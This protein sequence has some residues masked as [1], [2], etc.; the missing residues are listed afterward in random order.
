LVC[1]DE[2]I[3]KKE[4]QERVWGQNCLQCAFENKA[5]V[6][7]DKVVEIQQYA[8][9]HDITLRGKKMFPQ[10]MRYRPFYY[11]YLTEDAQELDALEQGLSAAIFIAKTLA[12]SSK[13]ELGFVP[14]LCEQ[15][16]IPYLVPEQ[17]GYRFEKI[18][19][20]PKLEICY[21]QPRFPNDIAAAK[22]KREKKKA[23]WMSELFR[24]PDATIPEGGEVPGFPMVLLSIDRESDFVYCL[25][26]VH[27][28][29]SMLMNL[30]DD[31]LRT[32][33]DELVQQL[34]LMAGTEFMPE[35]LEKRLSRIFH[36]NTKEAVPSATFPK[37]NAFG[38]YLI[39][40]ALN[41]NCY[42]QIQISARHTLFQLH[43][44]ILEAF[45][46][47]DDHAHAFFMNNQSWSKEDAY[48]VSWMEE[49][50]LATDEIQLGRLGLVAGKQ[51]KYIFDFG[52]EWEFQCKVL[53]VLD[54]DT[55][56]PFVTASKGKAPN[57]YM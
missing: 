36:W 49:D 42:R 53:K 20:P 39:Y 41:D 35:S 46:F 23:V 26:T 13:E 56:M 51:F 47:T 55:T 38:S 18:D 24:L 45:G 44:A 29:I 11:P 3:D 14:F 21:P 25:D 48:Y 16:T 54:M 9:L 27:N 17:D 7:E 33:P 12:K 8:H 37:L 10:F 34:S 5:L 15:M 1:S 31:E 6:A 40:V 4:L 30:S 2:D 50:G 28:V 52:E 22:I 19:L 57:Q 32:M 43:G